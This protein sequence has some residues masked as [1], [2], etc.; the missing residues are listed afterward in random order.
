[1]RNMRPVTLVA[2]DKVAEWLPKNVVFKHFLLLSFE[3]FS[4]AAKF[5]TP[6]QRVLECSSAFR[7]S[8]DCRSSL[9][10]SRMHIRLG[11][12]RRRLDSVPVRSYIERPFLRSIFTAL[13][14]S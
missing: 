7:Q 13:I 9:N 2:L 14:L 11:R 10:S 12:R 4:P 8:N 6:G 5:A 1:M 3:D